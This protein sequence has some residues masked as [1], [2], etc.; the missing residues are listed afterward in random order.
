MPVSDPMRHVRA[1]ADE[2][3]PRAPTSAQERQAAEYIRD[4]MRRW[5]AEVRVEPFRS[6]TSF[7]W[8]WLLIYACTVAAGVLLWQRPL[9]AFVVGAVGAVLFVGQA[10]GW[11]DVGAL[12]VH[13]PSQNVVGIVPARR[14]T[15][16]RVVLVGHMDTNRA[17]LF[18]HPRQVGTFR[19]T[20]LMGV[21]ATLAVPVIALVA[22]LWPWPHW[23]WVGLPFALNMVG[24]MLMLVHREIFERHV[25]GANDNASGVAVTLEA[26]A[27]LAAEPLEHTE[28]WCLVTGCEE[29]GTVGMRRFLDR[30]GAR[31][32]DAWFVV[33][34]NFGTGQL[35]FA[36]SEGILGQRPS[37]PDLLALSRSIAARHPEWEMVEG[38]NRLLPTDMGPALERGFKAV[39]VRAEDE[40]GLL[41]NWHWYTDTSDRVD[42]QNL[43]RVKQFVCE[44]A[45]ALDDRLPRRSTSG[46]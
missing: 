32:K 29:A 39:H 7:A 28:V 36:R 43:A 4:Q 15:R 24:S 42:P 23:G 31:L 5:A 34:D 46:G 25:P 17:A 44:L 19:T 16:Q 38:D 13:R 22:L 11:F 41:P 10:R 27:A 21:A 14:Q 45:G 1:L 40:S 18:F 12:F 37:D 26:G 6:Y 30:H 20:F 8:P 33:L 35:K 2:I 3:G 9:P